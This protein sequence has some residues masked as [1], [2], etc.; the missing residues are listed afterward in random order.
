MILYFYS[1]PLPQ[2]ILT[3]LP[4]PM[5]SEEVQN[6]IAVQDYLDLLEL[7]FEGVDP[8][9]RDAVRHEQFKVLAL[10]NHLE[11]EARQFWPTS[12][13]DKMT[14]YCQSFKATISHTIRQGQLVFA[15]C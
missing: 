15:G 10:L 8:Q 1:S 6:A 12:K 5:I 3:F 13:A 2:P 7:R 9:L 14:T 4:V 11:D